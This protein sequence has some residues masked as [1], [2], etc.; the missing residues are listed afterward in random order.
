MPLR[1]KTRCRHP[2]CPRLTRDRLCDEHRGSYSRLSDARRGTASDR[3]YDRA[4]DDVADARRRLDY[5]L[6]QPCRAEDRL[7]PS[8]IVDHIIP[9]H[10][11]PDWRLA[12]SNTQVICRVCHSA[13]TAEDNNR[14]G[15]STQ[16]RLTSEQ[17]EKRRQATELSE[18]PRGN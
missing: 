7:T 4:W 9:V 1:M 10:V 14:Y 6:C 16:E 8:R 17:Q 5:G 13:K 15:S 11:R 18:P 12:I 2:G 3:G